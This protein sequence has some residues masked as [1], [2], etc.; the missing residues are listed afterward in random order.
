M[1]MT[2]L[3]AG[4]VLYHGTA[5][6]EFEEADDHLDGPAWLTDS[7]AVAERFARRNAQ[8]S[9]SKPRVL[10]YTLDSD[11][12]LHLIRGRADLDELT[13]EHGISFNGV[14]EMRD[15]VSDAGIPGWVIPSNYPEGADIL[16]ADT[17][18]LRYES[19]RA[20]DEEPVV[21][22]ARRPRPR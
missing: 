9:D 20:L 8:G 10:T 14:E 22:R 4:T 6:T 13:E 2:T 5:M 17:G 18:A 1:P 21:E 15:T 19:T 7:E 16:L 12:E 11:I 3:K